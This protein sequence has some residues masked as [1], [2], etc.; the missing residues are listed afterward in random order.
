MA[1]RISQAVL[2]LT[3]A[4][5]GL[6]TIAAISYYK[7]KKRNRSANNTRTTR[8]TATATESTTGR[9]NTVTGNTSRSAARLRRARSIRR[10]TRNEDQGRSQLIPAGAS[11]N[12]NNN[13]NNNNTNT[14]VDDLFLSDTEEELVSGR[15]LSLFKEWSEDDNKNLLNLLYAIS[16]N[17]S[18]KEGYIHRGITCNKC[19]MS[20]I[21]GVRY[22]CANCV[23][24][25]LCEMCE[26][27][28]T[29]I[30]TH[31]FLKIR[32]PIPPLANP[33]NAL[34]SPLYPGKHRSKISSS[35][36]AYTLT[37]ERYKKLEQSSHFD[38]VELEALY[39]Q[40]K[41]LST[42][43]KD[44]GGIDQDTFRQCL[45]PLGLEKSLVTERIFAFFDQDGDGTIT[46]DEL[47][48]G[49]SVLCKGNFDEKIEQKQRLDAFKGYDLD[50]DGY[51]SKDELYRMYKSYFYLSMELV[52]DVVSAMEDEMM[53]S[54]EFSASQPVSAAFNVAMPSSSITRRHRPSSD[55]SST[56]DH[57]S[58]SSSSS[59][60]E[61]ENDS[62]RSENDSSSEDSDD[63]SA[64]DDEDEEEKQVSTDVTSDDSDGDDL[65]NTSSSHSDSDEEQQEDEDEA[66]TSIQHPMDPSSSSSVHCNHHHINF[67]K[68]PK[69]PRRSKKS[70]YPEK[71]DHFLQQSNR[72]AEHAR[73][74]S[75]VSQSELNEIADSAL[76]ADSQHFF[77]VSPKQKS[78][79]T[80][81]KS[82]SK[83]KQDAS[84]ELEKQS[85]KKAW[86]ER[87]PIMETMSQGAIH[88]M[89]DNTFA[90]I[91]TEREGYISFREFR[92]CVQHDPSIVSWFEALGTV[93]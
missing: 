28:K 45:G 62:S 93:F 17:Q 63:S 90:N 81:N 80:N 27:S 68:Q 40:Y 30:N 87:F 11:S 35:S 12:S 88:E 61:S 32:I 84:G 69:R 79:N 7:N 75:T 33:R 14:N 43:D 2:L 20:P 4:I 58:S 29:H 72:E 56:T 3:G 71:E 6:A 39:E 76:R 77:M 53:D 60:S 23:D 74:L 49:L 13:N 22:K 8:S 50:G 38:Q 15:I 92:E 34:L 82:K 36:L 55:T 83:N 86:K 24:F 85:K 37:S 73:A 66:T 65:E 9:S 57:D 52:R 19:N 78:D 70:R 31:V 91:Q 41:S 42:V 21:R 46:F 44:G 26:G 47:V 1:P 64:S 25:D 67:K 54:F 16:E 51:I 5:T 10:R 18:M 48:A 89:V 59:E